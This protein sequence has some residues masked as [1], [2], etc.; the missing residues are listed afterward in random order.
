M[1]KVPTCVGRADCMLEPKQNEEEV[2]KDG[3]LGL[4]EMIPTGWGP[5]MGQEA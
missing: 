2:H 1:C 5:Y 4:Y 3:Q